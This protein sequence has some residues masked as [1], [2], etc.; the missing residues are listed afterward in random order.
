MDEVELDGK[1]RT[2]GEADVVEDEERYA[3]D[4]VIAKAE[5][6]AIG[7]SMSLFGERSDRKIGR[8]RRAVWSGSTSEK[9]MTKRREKKK[10]KRNKRLREE[11]RGACSSR[12][13]GYREDNLGL[14][15]P[16]HLDLV[17]VGWPK[18]RKALSTICC[19][20]GWAAGK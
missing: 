6:Y 3:I 2:T 8:L 15:K 12:V 20:M 14:L 4:I 17:G 7:R 16:I 1:Y 10:R 5:Q 11:G 19:I 18:C 13:N 9:K